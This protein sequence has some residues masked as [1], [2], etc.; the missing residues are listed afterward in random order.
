[1]KIRQA[2]NELFHVD[3]RTDTRIDMNKL[4][5]ALRNFAN[6]FRNEFY[7]IIFFNSIIFSQMYLRSKLLNQHILCGIFVAV[8][9]ENHIELINKLCVKMYSGMV[10]QPALRNFVTRS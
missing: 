9:C 2:K 6:P 4:S 8:Y 5:V 1:M 3:G 10:L 7:A